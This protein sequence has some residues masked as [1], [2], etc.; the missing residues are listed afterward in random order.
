MV[1]KELLVILSHWRRP[2][3]AHN[4][5]IRTQAAYNTM[6]VFALDTVSKLVGKEMGA[7]MKV[8]VSPSV[9]L[10]EESLLGIWW[11]ELA[12][13]VNT[14]TPTTWTLFYRAVSGS[15][16]TQVKNHKTCVLMMIAMARFSHSHHM[17]KIQKLMTIYFK[18]CGLTTKAFDTLHALGITMSQKWSYDGIEALSKHAHLDMAWE[19]LTSSQY[20]NMIMTIFFFVGSTNKGIINGMVFPAPV[21]AIAIQSRPKRRASLSP[22]LQ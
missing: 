18:S 4:A 14:V 6:N 1:S 8:M 17:C 22:L 9:D 12:L 21:P 2:P 13:E 15:T 3:Q 7:L 5:G 11:K 19:W 20:S 10:S 16:D